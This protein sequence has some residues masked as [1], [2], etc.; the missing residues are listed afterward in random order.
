MLQNLGLVEKIVDAPSK[1]A[2]IPIQDAFEILRARYVLCQK[3][4][5][6]LYSA[7]LGKLVR[8]RNSHSFACAFFHI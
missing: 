7:F 8:I 5:L 2:A 6:L 4:M 3:I 1:Y